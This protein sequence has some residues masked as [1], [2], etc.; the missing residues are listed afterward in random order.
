MQL[1]DRK[2]SFGMQ[3]DDVALLHL[4]LAK[5]CEA[6]ILDAEISFRVDHLEESDIVHPSNMLAIGDRGLSSIT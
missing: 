6:R 5:L 1:Q 4:E 2:L 3:G